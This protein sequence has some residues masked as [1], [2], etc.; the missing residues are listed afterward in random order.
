MFINTGNFSRFIVSF[1][2]QSA[3]IVMLCLSLSCSSNVVS[4][5]GES[6]RNE[7]SKRNKIVHDPGVVEKH[8]REETQAWEGVPH[9]LGGTDRRG[10]DCSGFVRAV[11]KNVFYLELPRTTEEQVKEGDFV[12]RLDLRAGDLVFFRQPDS[13]RHVGIYLSGNEFVHAS[14]SKGIII[15]E[16]NRHYWGK[17]YWTARRILKK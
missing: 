7:G 17:Y 16:M 11:Y 2:C 15:S 4:T 12:G 3:F 10:I 6:L 5:N 8:L 1:L 14:K 9:R 13:Q